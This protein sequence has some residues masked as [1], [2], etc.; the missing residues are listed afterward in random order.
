MDAQRKPGDGKGARSHQKPP[1]PGLASAWISAVV[2]FTLSVG[3]LVVVFSVVGRM[4]WPTSQSAPAGAGQFEWIFID[5]LIVFLAY[6]AARSSFRSALRHEAKHL[7][8]MENRS[9]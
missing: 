4:P 5:A 7:E 9:V 3:I 6:V 2:V 1:P 8:Q